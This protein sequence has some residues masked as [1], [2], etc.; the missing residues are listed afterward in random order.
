[1]KEN[2]AQ[3]IPAFLQEILSIAKDATQMPA[4]A[5]SLCINQSRNLNNIKVDVHVVMPPKRGFI[6]RLWANLF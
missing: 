5:Q 3:V 4:P 2:Q 1:M 6:Q